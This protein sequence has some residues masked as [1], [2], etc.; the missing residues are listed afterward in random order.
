MASFDSLPAELVDYIVNLS[1]PP[2]HHK[3]WKERRDIL[4]A[5]SLTCHA[6][7]HPARRLLYRDVYLFCL[8]APLNFSHLAERFVAAYLGAAAADESVRIRRLEALCAWE[9]TGWP[10][11]EASSAAPITDLLRLS[12]PVDVKMQGAGS[13][14]VE[15]LADLVNTQLRVLNNTRL[16]APPPFSPF[17]ALRRLGLRDVGVAAPHALLSPAALPSLV[18]LAFENVYTLDSAAPGTFKA[19]VPPDLAHLHAYSTATVFPDASGPFPSSCQVFDLAVT[20]TL[21]SHVKVL[22]PTMA[23]LRLTATNITWLDQRTLARMLDAL[24]SA[25]PQ[26]AL[27]EQHL[28]NFPAGVEG[29]NVEEWC[30]QRWVRLVEEEAEDAGHVFAPALWRF[31][32]DVRD[33]FGLDV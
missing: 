10:R 30:S 21:V 24:S 33:R 28:V 26:P 4:L 31:L 19:V 1:A 18:S 15:E 9:G 23:V 14:G 5:L 7:R 29:L 16:V 17:R 13:L 3:T 12:A 6:T 32:E 8:D 2:F 22:P 25:Q 27:K 20:P 11:V